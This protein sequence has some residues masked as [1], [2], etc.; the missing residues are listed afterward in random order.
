MFGQ[1][2]GGVHD[3]EDQGGEHLGQRLAWPSSAPLGQGGQDRAE[4]LAKCSL[5]TSGNQGRGVGVA[6]N[7]LFF[8]PLFAIGGWTN[9]VLPSDFPKGISL[10]RSQSFLIHGVRQKNLGGS[11]GFLK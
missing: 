10:H 5:K 2:A 1:C 3:M 9:T 7:R 11:A 4:T 6:D 8:M